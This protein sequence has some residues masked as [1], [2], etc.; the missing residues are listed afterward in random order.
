M[1]IQDAI[2]GLLAHRVE[3]RPIFVVGGSRS[4][5]SVLLHALGRHRRI[6]S[7]NGEDPF[8]TD[9]GG[10]VFDLAFAD[11]REL[12]YYSSSLRVSQSYIFK[13]L[14][15]LAYESAFGRH[16]GLYRM[17]KDMVN[18]GYNVLT[19]THWSAKTFPVKK[20]AQGLLKLYPS[21]RFVM[22]HRSGIDVIN[23]RTKFHGFKELD[24]RRQCEEWAR[25]INTYSY[26]IDFDQAITVRHS[27]LLDAPE[28]LFKRVFEFIGLEYDSVPAHFARTNHV[29]PLDKVANESDVDVRTLMASRQPAH[30]DWSE[31]QRDIF[32]EVCSEPMAKMG[33]E[34]PF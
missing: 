4:G 15:K 21:A 7:F 22:I 30:A 14:K 23:S 24:F 28:N 10:M 3:D 31:Q 29:H 6:Y 33:Y 1:C 19:K 25:S 34:I 5:T 13:A 17:A 16:Y 32:R 12:E 8:L 18:G 26:L 9:V 20:V 27:D 11:D 2:G